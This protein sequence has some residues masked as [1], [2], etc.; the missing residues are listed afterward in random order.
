MLPTYIE[1]RDRRWTFVYDQPALVSMPYGF[2][3]IKEKPIYTSITEEQHFLHDVYT[4]VTPQN[5]FPWIIAHLFN[6]D[7]NLYIKGDKHFGTGVQLGVIW[8]NNSYTKIRLDS[9]LPTI[10]NHISQIHNDA[11]IKIKEAFFTWIPPITTS[12]D[13]NAA[14]PQAESPLKEPA[15]QHETAFSND[16][17]KTQQETTPNNLSQRLGEYLNSHKTTD[18]SKPKENLG[19]EAKSDVFKERLK[20]LIQRVEKAIESSEEPSRPPKTQDNIPIPA[21]FLLLNADQASYNLPAVIVKEQP[22]MPLH[23]Q[24]NWMI[25]PFPPNKAEVSG[26]STGIKKDNATKSLDSSL[27]IKKVIP[28]PP[29]NNFPSIATPS[30]PNYVNVETPKKSIIAQENTALVLVANPSPIQEKRIPIFNKEVDKFNVTLTL[31]KSTTE[32]LALVIYKKA[33][34]IC[35]LGDEPASLVLYNHEVNYCSYSYLLLFCASE[36]IMQKITPRNLCNILKGKQNNNEQCKDSDKPKIKQKEEATGYSLWEWIIGGGAVIVMGLGAPFMKKKGTDIFKSFRAGGG[37]GGN[38]NLTLQNFPALVSYLPNELINIFDAN[39]LIEN[40]FDNNEFIHDVFDNNEFIRDVFDN[41]TYFY[42]KSDWNLSLLCFIPF[43]RSTNTDLNKIEYNNDVFNRD[44]QHL[45]EIVVVEEDGMEKMTDDSYVTPTKTQ[46]NNSA[47]TQQEINELGNSLNTLKK[48]IDQEYIEKI[49]NESN[50]RKSSA[51]SRSTTD[52]IEVEVP[53]INR[54]FD[55]DSMDNDEEQTGNNIIYPE[56]ISPSKTPQKNSLEIKQKIDELKRNIYMLQKRIALSKSHFSDY[57]KKIQKSENELK[58]ERENVQ[59]AIQDSKTN[60]ERAERECE[61]KKNHKEKIDQELKNKKDNLKKIEEELAEA[62]KEKI[63]LDQPQQCD[64][65]EL[66]K[67][68]GIEKSERNIYAENQMDILCEMNAELKIKAKE[69]AQEKIK[70]L[71]DESEELMHR[72][73]DLTEQ[74]ETLFKEI[75]ILE[76]EKLTYQNIEQ[77]ISKQNKK[78]R[79]FEKE[80]QEIIDNAS[81]KSKPLEYELTELNCELTTATSSLQELLSAQYDYISPN[82]LESTSGYTK[83]N[84]GTELNVNQVYTENNIITEI[85]GLTTNVMHVNGELNLNPGYDGNNGG[86]DL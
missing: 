23:H 2:F 28:I 24:F 10:A 70:T 53:K 45:S 43:T 81:N 50:N 74:S 19:T 64:L 60:K 78:L 57:I 26:D 49:D 31:L 14:E 46:K 71:E 37:S 58:Q 18:D 75:L 22:A 62:N 30:T 6:T 7:D 8:E 27:T 48:L 36:N 15:P 66:E 33:V 34:E 40:V 12:E 83:N 9:Q 13:V 17:N 11:G 67:R 52:T 69:T 1:N 84:D 72:I 51:D 68:F 4:K 21:D 77:Y 5:Y 55:F 85:S 59:K 42:P 35:A 38:D 56:Y 32:P 54:S 44:M 16:E 79:N 25:M 41:I 39:K 76:C 61:E 82:K 80:N 47:A 63:K 29:Y 65:D 20:I 73:N 86:G 3:Y